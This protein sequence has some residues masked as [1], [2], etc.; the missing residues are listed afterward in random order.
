MSETDRQRWNLRYQEQAPRTQPSD[1]LTSLDALVPRCGKAL[2][3]GGG[4]GR[5]AIWLAHRGL[6]VTLVDI[7]DVAIACAKQAATIAGVD[8]QTVTIDLDVEPLPNGP[9]D[10]ILCINFLM[11][12]LFAAFAAALRPGGL[13]VFAQ[14]TRTNLTRHDKPGAAF[15]LEDGELPNLI[16]GLEIIQ[17]DEGWTR[18]GRHEARVVARKPMR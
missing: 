5:H 18:E 12:P 6:E 16:Q 14:P 8:L 11:R 10:L 17:Y 15:L 2:D 9:W 3:V 4:A 1:F 7:S 13:L